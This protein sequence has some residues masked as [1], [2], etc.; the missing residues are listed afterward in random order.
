LELESGG[1][2]WPFATAV[3]ADFLPWLVH[4]LSPEPPTMS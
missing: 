2:T 4:A 3:F 1:H